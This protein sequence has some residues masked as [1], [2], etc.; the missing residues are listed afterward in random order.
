MSLFNL[1]TSLNISGDGREASKK[2]LVDDSFGFD[3][4]F[5]EVFGQALQ[6]QA[7]PQEA[8]AQVQPEETL[9]AESPNA[10]ISLVEAGEQAMLPAELNGN[11]PEDSEQETT[12]GD[13]WQS[14]FFP[15]NIISSLQAL[16]NPQPEKPSVENNGEPPAQQ[17]EGWAV[18]KIEAGQPPADADLKAMA[19]S[20]L[21]AQDTKARIP[22]AAVPAEESVINSA[23]SEPVDTPAESL[24]KK[25][26]AES[27]GFSSSK[28]LM[29]K[30]EPVKNAEP[31]SAESQSVAGNPQLVSM[32]VLQPF[33]QHAQANSPVETPSPLEAPNPV[34]NAVGPQAHPQEFAHPMTKINHQSEAYVHAVQAQNAN[35]IPEHRPLPAQAEE[36]AFT[37]EMP[38]L[39]TTP[40]DG[41]ASSFPLEQQALTEAVTMD[42][43]FQISA[44]SPS[45][46][47]KATT[48]ASTA[49]KL[50]SGIATPSQTTEGPLKSNLL[51]EIHSQLAALNGQVESFSEGDAETLALE[52][53]AEPV[54]LN[55]EPGSPL[56][57]S[58]SME[59]IPKPAPGA[60][61]EK[62]HVFVPSAAHPADQVV[63][64]T[65]YSMKNGHQ[66]LV[67]R[68]NPDNL[69]EVRVNLSTSGNGSLS[70]RLIASS[71]ESHEA[72]QSHLSHLKSA[73][74]AQGVQLERL[75]VVIAGQAE[76]SSQTGQQ[77]QSQ[78]HFQQQ[79][80]QQQKMAQQDFNQQQQNQPNA[81]LAFNLGQQ[82]G[83]HSAKSP[84][85][86]AP[87]AP[88]NRQ[89]PGITTGESP[90]NLNRQNDNGSIS[91]LA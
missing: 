89:E 71:A 61:P 10:E 59:Q 40:V 42:A 45:S 16:L 76:S 75:S 84:Y 22:L 5:S 11:P 58:L 19:L 54:D 24:L 62:A 31:A 52:P 7:L 15:L 72:L 12:S 13:G 23:E 2:A 38:I 63:E 29:K 43:S 64:G 68:L 66:E 50:Q 9:I 39:S 57:P 65:V 83:G 17:A 46:G 73:L 41:L 81:Q 14:T 55:A 32:E 33:L 20:G 67:I 69:G 87:S 53:T 34:Q 25:S 85:A 86:Q 37:S 90:R 3:E 44:P 70:A 18:L 6:E 8:L 4:K 27:S 80:A 28:E 35:V 56:M 77:G 26:K 48:D 88:V 82:N 91:I 1:I 30:E 74:E 47:K 36:M 78:Q 21:P 79:D 60:N 49:L 51:N